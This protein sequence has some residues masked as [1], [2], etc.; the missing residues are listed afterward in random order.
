MHQESQKQG[1]VVFGSSFEVLIE[2]GHELNSFSR[3]FSG[4]L[5]PIEVNLM[6]LSLEQTL[7]L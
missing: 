2:S 5:S 3:R 7:G 1:R 4:D 6:Y